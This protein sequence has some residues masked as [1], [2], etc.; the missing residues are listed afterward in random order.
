MFAREPTETIYNIVRSQSPEMSISVQFSRN[1]GLLTV[2]S[3]LLSVQIFVFTL[4]G[5]A[6]LDLTDKCD[7][8]NTTS[9]AKKTTKL[10]RTGR[11]SV[12]SFAERKRL[13]LHGFPP[14]FFFFLNIRDI[15]KRN[16][17]W[18]SSENCGTQQH[19]RLRV[20]RILEKNLHNISIYIY[21]Y[22]NTRRNNKRR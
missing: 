17:S 20:Y 6:K 5:H 1:S 11:T 7:K 4:I 15:F 16:R 18:S 2:D 3:N 9:C 19:H 12:F 21:I 8:C 14:F 10:F 22:K 13:K